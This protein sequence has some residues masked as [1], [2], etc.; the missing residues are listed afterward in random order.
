MLKTI[1][2]LENEKNSKG[3]KISTLEDIEKY[4]EIDK[5]TNKGRKHNNHEH[6]KEKE[7]EKEKEK[8]NN[9]E[10]NLLANKIERHYQFNKISK[11]KKM[12][13]IFEEDEFKLVKEMPLARSTFYDIKIKI[14]E[15]AN[16]FES[17][18]NE[19]SENFKEKIEN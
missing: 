15:I 10:K 13:E 6:N 18:K 19:K 2:K 12:E 16:I 11:E 7:K 14:N 5:N 8:D 1:N 4:F 3:G 9:N 17:K